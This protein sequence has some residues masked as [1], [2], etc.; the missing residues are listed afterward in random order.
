MAQHHRE[1]RKCKRL[2]ALAKQPKRTFTA[3]EALG[4][5]AQIEACETSRFGRGRMLQYD[6]NRS[7]P[8]HDDVSSTLMTFV[9]YAALRAEQLAARAPK[10]ARR[11]DQVVA[12]LLRA[13]AS[14]AL[15]L[16]GDSDLA[17][18]VTVALIWEPLE[19]AVYVLRAVARM[20]SSKA[21]EL[22][23]SSECGCAGCTAPGA[24]PLLRWSGGCGHMCCAECVWERFGEREL[25]CP[26]CGAPC[27]GPTTT[28]SPGGTVTTAVATGSSPVPLESSGARDSLNRYLALPATLAADAGKK[29]SVQFKALNLVAASRLNLGCTRE[30]RDDRLAIAVQRGDCVRL[31]ALVQAGVNLAVASDYGQ[32][33][34]FIAA[35]LG[36]APLVALLCRLGV[37]LDQRDNSGSTPLDAAVRAGHL[38]TAQ[39]LRDAGATESSDAARGV[40]SEVGGAVEVLVDPRSEHSSAGSAFIDGGFS[41]EFLKRLDAVERAIPPKQ[42]SAA[43]AALHGKKAVSCASRSFFC[44]TAGW[45]RRSI[46]EALRAALREAGG[47]DYLAD[48]TIEVRSKMRFLRYDAIGGV[49]PPHTDLPKMDD[50]AACLGG[51]RTRSTHTFL[52]YLSEDELGGGTALLAE[53]PRGT[54]GKSGERGEDAPAPLGVVLPRRGRFFF[55]PH[56]CP[57][58]GLAVCCPP[59]V[60]LR[61]ELVIT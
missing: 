14:A 19:F 29:P 4:V 16:P 10:R 25:R 38:D 47:L 32:R 11:C 54:V 56:A 36:H 2:A 20:R 41:D 17:Q 24:A 27:A 37:D 21:S 39:L 23:E 6:L 55:F 59:K 30:H 57:H 60:L 45:V 61:G 43:V 58:E 1:E 3:D 13:G 31:L 42:Q 15:Y 5:F 50:R 34:L 49:L 44:D 53:L 7:Y 51:V 22:G 52:L 18:R 33:P 9:A 8:T 46:A 12:S 35:S 26:Q 28:T 40:P 48:A